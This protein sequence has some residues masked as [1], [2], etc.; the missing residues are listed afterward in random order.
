MGTGSYPRAMK[1]A[2][3]KI[4]RE[5]ERFP[6]GSPLGSGWRRRGPRGTR[7]QEKNLPKLYERSQ[8]T[9][10]R[11]REKERGNKSGEVNGNSG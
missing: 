2:G 5:E 8:K 7:N 9:Q 3:E 1:K 6:Q 11:G 10:K 4:K